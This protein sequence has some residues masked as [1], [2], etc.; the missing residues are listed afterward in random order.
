VENVPAKILKILHL[1]SFSNLA[2][3]LARLERKNEAVTSELGLCSIESISASSFGEEIDCQ[4]TLANS[5]LP[6]AMQALSDA[7]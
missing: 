2:S 5:A 1:R 3:N 6:D 7:M 4:L